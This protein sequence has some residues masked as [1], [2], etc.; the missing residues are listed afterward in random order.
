MTHDQPQPKPERS[1]FEEWRDKYYDKLRTSGRVPDDWKPSDKD[2][3][4]L[5]QLMDFLVK[6][7]PA[8]RPDEPTEVNIATSAGECE[9]SRDFQ[10]ER[11]STYKATNSAEK[12]TYKVTD[13]PDE[14]QARE[15]LLF[16]SCDPAD[17]D[18]KTLCNYAHILKCR[19]E[20]R[21]IEYAAYKRV[22]DERDELRFEF[23]AKQRPLG[24]QVLVLTLE[25]DAKAKECDELREAHELVCTMY[26]SACRDLKDICAIRDE[27][28]AEVERLKDVIRDLDTDCHG[29][30]TYAADLKE[31]RDK[32]RAERD[33]LRAALTGLLADTEH[34]DHDC[35]D[36][37]CPVRIAR[38][39]L[40]A[41][42][43]VAD[44]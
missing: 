30:E 33:W 14:P 37:D 5:Q 44:K 42:R 22:C 23:E 32:L 17:Y 43:N 36:S 34:A 13:R 8:S 12:S 20:V 1:E 11:P 24:E 25:R 7:P 21:V 19:E 27:L 40:S 28:R 3:E 41:S 9:K 2:N 31:E 16:G 35:G 26:E 10:G 29:A 39:A 4:Q 18:G 15:W 38:E 6:G